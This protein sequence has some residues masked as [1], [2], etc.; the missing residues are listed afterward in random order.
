MGSYRSDDTENRISKTL[1]G[2][3]QALVPLFSPED[4]TNSEGEGHLQIA[5]YMEYN[6]RGLAKA[7]IWIAVSIS[8]A[9]L[10]G[11]LS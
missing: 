3:G 11:Q 1:D 10:I 9:L 5:K 8:I 2:S 7:V 6:I 4:T